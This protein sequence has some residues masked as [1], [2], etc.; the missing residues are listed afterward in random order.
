MNPFVHEEISFKVKD[1]FVFEVIASF[2][3]IS[4]Q[5]LI[6]NNVHII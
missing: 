1:K 2:F 5:G 3:V 6:L 4:I